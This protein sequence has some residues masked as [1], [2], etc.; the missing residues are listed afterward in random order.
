MPPSPTPPVELT[1]RI[2][3]ERD[4]DNAQEAA[5]EF[6][7]PASRKPEIPQFTEAIDA[8][9]ECKKGEVMPPD[10]RKAYRRRKI[11]EAL[12]RYREERGMTQEVAGRLLDRSAS[13]LS[14]FEN[15]YQSIRPRDLAYILDAYGVSD[16][17]ER[18]RLLALVGQGR[19][20][21]WWHDFR[22]RLEPGVLDFASLEADATRIRSFEPQLVPGLLQTEDYARSIISGAGTS[23]PNMRN[24]E[25][26]VEF[27]MRRQRQLAQAGHPEMAVVIGE[28][29]L[30]QCVGSPQTMRAQMEKIAGAARLPHFDIRVLPY[31]AGVHPGVDGSFVILDLGHETQLQVVALHSLTRSW[32][33]EEPDEIDLYC[34]SFDRLQEMALD[35]D[36]SRE[37]LHGIVSRT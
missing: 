30:L 21:G 33:V 8:R 4:R 18:G 27:R 5:V 15:G 6:W 12:R 11:G 19:Q 24:I 32:Y 36:Q 14:A 16:P 28:G 3:A 31:A 26:G 37:L 34:R 9:T 17:D 10:N 29:A 2:L 13:S 35:K 22:Q 25:T 1:A 7:F 23:L 20:Y